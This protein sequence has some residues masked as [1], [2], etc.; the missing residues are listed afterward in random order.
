MFLDK[1]EA[2]VRKDEASV[3]HS[4]LFPTSLHLHLHTPAPGVSRQVSGVRCQAP[5]VPLLPPPVLQPGKEHP[6]APPLPPE[7]PKIIPPPGAHSP[8]QAVRWWLGGGEVVVSW[9]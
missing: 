4:A 3:L 2:T 1:I 9:W 6:P 8:A 7:Y 5:P